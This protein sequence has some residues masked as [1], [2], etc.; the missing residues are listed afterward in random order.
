MT[1]KPAGGAA[2]GGGGD[3]GPDGRVFVAVGMALVVGAG[4][5]G[6]V[7]RRRRPNRG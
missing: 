2:T 4:M 3:A 6:L 7:I 5:G 1:K